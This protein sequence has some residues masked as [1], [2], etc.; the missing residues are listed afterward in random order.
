[1]EEYLIETLNIDYMNFHIQEKG[2]GLKNQ[3]RQVCSIYSDNQNFQLIQIIDAFC[4][5]MHFFEF[6]Y[7]FT[8][9]V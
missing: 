6:F 5:R 9:Y 3:S 2:H 4:C 8:E 7:E 1:M